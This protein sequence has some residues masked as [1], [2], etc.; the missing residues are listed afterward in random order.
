MVFRS[1]CLL[2]LTLKISYANIIYDKNGVTITDIE[3]NKYIN[4]YNLSQGVDLPKNIA[5]KKFIL[6]R[7]TINSIEQNN[8][9]YIDLLDNRIKLEYKA[10]IY[11][12]PLLK[13]FIR[14]Q[15][16]RNEFIAEYFQ[17]RFN[18]EDLSLIFLNFSELKVPIS[19]NEC[20]T[21]EKLHIL[22][23]DQFFLENF[24]YNLKNNK[25]NFKTII[26]NNKYNICISNEMYSKIE[27]SIFK[28]IEIRTEEEFNKFIYEKIN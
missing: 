16:L 22:N 4:Y 17:Y 20:L 28:Y 21:I 10:S 26:N 23:N 24:F 27:Q 25:K 2:I 6:I 5:I 1:L 7:K 9:Q 12:D 8:S 19:K 14:Y 11:E 3:I 15:L 13:D 18:F